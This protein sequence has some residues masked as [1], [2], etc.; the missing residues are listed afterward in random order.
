MHNRLTIRPVLAAFRGKFYKKKNIYVR[1]LSYHTTTKI[2]KFKRVC[3]TKKFSWMHDFCV[4][5]SVISRR[6]RSR[7]KKGFSLWI[8]APGGTGIVWWKITEFQKFRDNASLTSWITVLSRLETNACLG[9][10]F[11][12]LKQY[13]LANE[14]SNLKASSAKWFGRDLV[15][16]L[17]VHI[18]LVLLFFI[19]KY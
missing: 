11:R 17:H 19:I 2:Y 3:L 4:R 9:D 7:I 13:C 8:W 14:R 10:P 6:I 16:S 1:E 15:R 18:W 12:T 5:K